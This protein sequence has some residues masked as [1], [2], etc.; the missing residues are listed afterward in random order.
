[1]TKA[2]SC[3]TKSTNQRRD[4]QKIVFEFYEAFFLW[5]IFKWSSKPGKLGT[6]TNCSTE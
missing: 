3:A 5:C 1:M 2:G 4:I 6:N